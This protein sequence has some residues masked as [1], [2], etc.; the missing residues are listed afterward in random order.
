MVE[1]RTWT[2]GTLLL[3]IC[4]LRVKRIRTNVTSDG[5]IQIFRVAADITVVSAVTVL[6]DFTEELRDL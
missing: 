3:T 4:V 5:I 1:V 2:V 6:D